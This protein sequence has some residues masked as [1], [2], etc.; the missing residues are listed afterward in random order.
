MRTPP[1]QASYFFYVE[2]G[3]RRD[4]ALHEPILAEGDDAAARAV[5]RAVAIRLGIAPEAID[6]LHKGKP[7]MPQKAAVW[8]VARA[9]ALALLEEQQRK[10]VLRTWANKSG[11]WDEGQHP[12]DDHGRFSDSGGGDGGG[13]GGAA[14]SESV[15]IAE[16]QKQSNAGSLYQAPTKTADEI[17][18][19]FKGGAAAIAATRERLKGIVPT[20]KSVEQGGF[21]RADGSYTPE[22]Q[23]VQQKI[24]DE[25]I[26]EET[27]KKSLP[28]GGE[29]P[30]LTILGGRGGSGK[31]WFTKTKIVDKDH[32][33]LLDSDEIKARLPEYQGWNAAQLHEESGDIASMIDKRAS[34]LGLNVILDGTLNTA[35]SIKERI[36]K[37][38]E[39]HPDYVLEGYYMY[40]SPEVATTRA[41]ERYAAGGTFEGRFVPPEVILA[42][43]TN[44]KN[45]DNLST[46]MRK[47]AVYDNNSEDFKPKLHSQ[48]K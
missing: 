41:M 36:G 40:A 43:T 18:A 27:I 11:D 42:N 14:P 5:S 48:S 31:S 3:K 47:W 12:R 19:G 46:G 7:M 44:E 35:A 25:F 24:V 6:A 23:K 29:P 26:N 33:I 13:G 30:V 21:K 16:P 39:G 17:V 38:R 4:A 20:N 1:K 15:T 34:E 28:K 9:R 32:A 37:Y 8:R 45:F 10:D 22:R 2:N